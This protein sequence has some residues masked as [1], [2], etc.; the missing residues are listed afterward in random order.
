[1]SNHHANA[2]WEKVLHNVLPYFPQIINA[3]AWNAD[4]GFLSILERLY[5]GH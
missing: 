1:M 2:V 4:I 5:L 3:V